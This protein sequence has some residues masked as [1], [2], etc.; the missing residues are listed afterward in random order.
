MIVGAEPERYTLPLRSSSSSSA[1]RPMAMPKLAVADMHWRLLP[2]PRFALSVLSLSER[3]TGVKELS[4]PRSR[5]LP[6]GNFEG[7]RYVSYLIQAYAMHIDSIQKGARA[8]RFDGRIGH[9]SKFS[10][11]AGGCEVLEAG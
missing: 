11:S 1:Y 6:V 5:A 7:E 3:S 9:H 8:H 2:P 10:E 4:Q